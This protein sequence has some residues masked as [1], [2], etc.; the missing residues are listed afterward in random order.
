MA[1]KIKCDQCG[2]LIELDKALS[3]ELEAKIKADF[4]SRFAEKNKS[5]EAKSEM[6][7]KKI[8]DLDKS[9]AER[10]DEEKRKLWDVAQKK[11][12]EKMSEKYIVEMKD[13]RESIKEKDESLKKLQEAELDLRKRARALEEK[14]RQMK[15]D[16][17]RKLD[18]ER[19]NMLEVERKKFDEEMQTRVSDN[20]KKIEEENRLKN[21]EKDKQLEQMRKTIEDLKRKSEQGSMQ[22]QGDVQEND[23]KRILEQEFPI[24]LISDVPTGIK[25]ADLIQTVRNSLGQESGIIVWESKRTKT[26]TYD[27]L[28]KLKDDQVIVK[29]DLAILVSQV[30]PDGVEGFKYIDG[31]WVCD[32]KSF[33]SLCSALR[34]QVL[35]ITKL[36]SSVVGRDEKMEVLFNYLS[37]AQFKNRIENIVHAFQSLKDELDREKR[38]FQRLWS[39]RE[40]EIERVMNNTVGMYGDLQGLIGGALPRIASLELDDGEFEDEKDSDL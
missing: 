20:S 25:G 10:L 31:V 4:E 5:L 37:S 17:E 36:K 16:M 22:I 13:L 32:Y 19:K 15:L 33:L 23:L 29:A 30:L 14:E 24:D 18:E 39:R 2:N 34:M 27:W 12:E 1:D 3:S 9:Y 26:W 8:K 35:E 7:E 6:F 28:K 11:A 40:K 38:S 21:L